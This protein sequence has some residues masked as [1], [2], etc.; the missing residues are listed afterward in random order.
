MPSL[1]HGLSGVTGEYFVCAEL[2][3]RG[4]IATLTLKN[5]EGIDILASRPGSGRAIS[6]QVKTRQSK[7]AH[8]V[9]NK[10]HENISSDQM[11]FLLVRL[12]S[13]GE[14]P[15]FYV[16]PGKIVA[17]SI[18]EGHKKWLKGTKRDG[19]QRKDTSM[20]GFNDRAHE[21]LE[22]WDLLDL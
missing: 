18:E 16:V 3:H 14:R 2:S 1:S 7:G 15:S 13:P 6:I 17:K 8:W 4:F 9:L 19:S 5:T 22:R 20:R 11:F 12:G 21:Y 10:K